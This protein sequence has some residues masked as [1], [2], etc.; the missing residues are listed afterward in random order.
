[1]FVRW[2]RSCNSRWAVG[3]P[4]RPD[5]PV[6]GGFLLKKLCSLLTLILTLF[7]AGALD[8]Q[9]A[10]VSVDKTS[11]SFSAQVGGSAQ[12]AQLTVTDA[13]SPSFVAYSNAQWLKINTVFTVGLP[14][15]STVTITV[16]PTNLQAGN[17]NGGIGVFGT[18][19]GPTITIPVTLSVGTIG[20]S[21]SSLAFAYQIGG[22]YPAS[23]ALTLSA[24]ST[25][26]YTS[27]FAAK[28]G[29]NWLLIP[30]N[31]SAPGSFSATL[32]PAVVGGL[33]A[34]TYTGTITITP[35]SGPAAAIP[36]TLTVSPAP[37][38]T[39]NP[40]TVN[41]NYQLN[42][43]TTGNTNTPSATLTLTNPGTQDLSY[44][45][46]PTA[47]PAGWLTV[48]PS[49]G[50]IP[51]NGTAA[52]TV[53][54][55]TSAN[56][57]AA[58]YS[59][60][61]A[62]FIPGAA[63]QQ[64]AVPV[65]LLVSNLPLLNVPNA[66]L[67]FSYQ[68]GGTVPA[69]KNV[70]ATSSNVTV[71]ATS[72]QMPFFVTKTTDNG[73]NDWLVVP[74]DTRQTGTPFTVSVNP[75]G[76]V[77]GKYT[78]TVTVTG[79]GAGNGAQTIPVTLTVSND[80]LIV[81]TFN[82][83]STQN[84]AC[85]MNFPIQIGQNNPTSQTIAVTSSTGAQASFTATVAMTASQACGTSWLSS[86]V[87]TAQ[88]GT[89]ASFPITVTPGSI[90]SGTTCTG[91]ITIAGTN[92]ANGAALPNSPVTIPVTMYV[93]SNPM[94][95]PGQA[96]LSFSVA[97]NATSFQ[98]LNVTSTSATA[99]LDFTATTPQNAPWL[100][101]TGTSRNTAAG[102]NSVIVAVNANTLAPGTY[103]SAVTL[104]ATATG[105]LDSPITVPVTLTVTAASMSVS[106][107]SLSFSQTKGASAPDTQKLTVSTSST[108]INF[109]VSVS[110]AKGT[111]W[112]TATASST[113]AT[114][115]TPAVITVKVDGSN[116]PP[117]TYQGAVTITST[118][119]FTSNGTVT[120]P[121]TLEVKPGTISATPTSLTFLQVQGGAA[122][123]AQSISV[124][125]VPGALSYTVTTSTN[126]NTGNWLS[127]D[128][129][130]GTTPGTIKVSVNGASLNPANYT[131]TVTIT[132][133]G[134]AGSPV[135]IPV[136]LTVASPQT[137]TVAPTSVNFSYVIGTTAPQ[138]QTV[139]LASSGTATPFTA[140]VSSDAS[141]LT[142]TPSSG[143]APATLTISVNPAGLTAN[144]YTG[145]ISINST[146][147]ANNPAASI[148]VN[149]TVQAVPKPNFTSVANAASYVNGPVSPGENIVIFG[150]GL[151]PA[152]LALGTVTNNAFDTTLSDTQVFFDNT[153][154]PIL[155]TSANQ[156]SVMVPYGVAGRTN[157]NIRVVY[158]GVQS[159][160][161]TYN[162]VAAAP[163]IYT[164]NAAGNG[165]GA[166]LNQD[167]SYN[168]ASTPAAKNSV[169]SVYMT[170]EGV[171]SPP[172]QDGVI[173][174]INGT[175]LFKPLQTVTATVGGIPAT[176]EYYGTAPGILYGV[177]QVN[178]RIPANAP[179]GANA[180]VINVG[181]N[182]A[183]PNV[184]VA[185]Q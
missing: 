13:G 117:D 40:T 155:Y 2:P 4:S 107:T 179:S 43:A 138:S 95:V 8:A 176:V 184:T 114:G 11:L 146:A 185:V 28:N 38:V 26:N 105:V 44:L 115:A 75:A 19:G 135:S 129:T 49:S 180:L 168:A 109:N 60:S 63:Q 121:V 182:H 17:Y 80:P 124:A 166:I 163:G 22:T 68:L 76:L 35:P 77:V 94:L 118:S 56:L 48:N 169:V 149:L 167:Y 58:N 127:V 106:P 64:I 78:G 174:P 74:S 145:K 133:T 141:W 113:T 79:I 89:T 3:V 34:D 150:T 143:T 57:P 62:V 7:A 178:V 91:T 72:G 33:A 69:A 70:L 82:G 23:A 171:T 50:T 111:G 27:T 97:P 90:V 24:A 59:G 61:L 29:G 31:G 154:A 98:T 51:A 122:P 136:T 14:T 73:G 12:S 67:A 10:T 55:A 93:S 137:V 37:A 177:M 15:P 83:C 142:V 71:D 172:S 46:T 140:S 181:S 110:T 5:C 96:A 112:L 128:T 183:Q 54:Y 153:P 39:A 104:T 36:V 125:G 1:M 159:D 101:A 85:P 134:A 88:V 151:G 47:T 53:A 84:T 52:I 126:G 30:Q 131:G 65:K 148:T 132:S 100:V 81:A 156:T 86:S 157:T 66:T 6:V 170:G 9:T 164:A 20:I 119:P 42:G 152:T 120:I 87:T 41:L 18:A 160:S 173:A 144:N 147:S 130:T 162:V 123:A 161:I 139:Q 92:P 45:I 25:T 21:A 102:S 99:N 165:Q 108:D 103:T 116:L 175:G 16:D 158:K 32:N